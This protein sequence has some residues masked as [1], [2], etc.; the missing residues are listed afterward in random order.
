MFLSPPILFAL[1]KF[2]RTSRTYYQHI[3]CTHNSYLNHTGSHVSLVWYYRNGGRDSLQQ[4][5]ITP[6]LLTYTDNFVFVTHIKLRKMILHKVSVTAQ[7]SEI[8][9]GFVLI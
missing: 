9:L 5:L 2:F 8:T 1:T 3:L 4:W 7:E 6:N